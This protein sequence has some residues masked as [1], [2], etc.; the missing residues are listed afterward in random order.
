MAISPPPILRL[1]FNMRFFILSSF[2]SQ[3]I[4]MNDFNMTNT[5]LDTFSVK[6]YFTQLKFVFTFSLQNQEQQIGVFATVHL[7]NVNKV[8]VRI[9]TVCKIY[10]LKKKKE[11]I[12]I[13]FRL[14]FLI[15]NV[16]V[17]KSRSIISRLNRKCNESISA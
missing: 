4:V 12:I 5:I 14:R 13:F 17:R 9:N 3:Q 16:A 6:Y 10:H 11:N 8:I 15:A 1:R 2:F 7:S